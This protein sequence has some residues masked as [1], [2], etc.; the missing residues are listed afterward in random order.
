MNLSNNL[1]VLQFLEFENVFILLIHQNPTYNDPNALMVSYS[2]DWRLSD[3][4][5]AQYLDD[6]W[7]LH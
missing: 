6:S 3:R 5:M 1:I 7:I 4:Q 2:D